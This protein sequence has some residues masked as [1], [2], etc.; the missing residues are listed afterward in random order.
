MCDKTADAADSGCPAPRRGR[1]RGGP[2]PSGEEDEGVEGDESAFTGE[3]R[4]ASL[5]LVEE[6]QRLTR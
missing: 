3:P 2:P 6:Y 1:R 4:A 5:E